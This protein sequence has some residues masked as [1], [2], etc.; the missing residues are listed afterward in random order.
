MLTFLGL[1]IIKPLKLSG[2][3]RIFTAS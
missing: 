3:N 2:H 1:S